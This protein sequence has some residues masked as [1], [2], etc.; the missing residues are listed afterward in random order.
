MEAGDKGF[1]L[2]PPTPVKGGGNCL[3]RARALGLD[4]ASPTSQHGPQLAG[5]LP[6][7]REGLLALREFTD[8]VNREQN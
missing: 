7:P 5:T 2:G 6:A 3:P 8:L 1:L 4:G